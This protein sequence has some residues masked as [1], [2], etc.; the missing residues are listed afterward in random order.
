[1]KKV[2]LAAFVL[3]VVFSACL[4][5]STTSSGCTF[6]A[7]SYTAPTSEIQ[8][9]QSYL[10]SHSLTATQHCSGLFYNITNSGTGTTPNACSNITVNYTASLTNGNVFDQQNNFSF[11]LLQAISGW[12]I[13]MPLLRSGGHIILYIPPSLGYGN[14]DIKDQNGNVIIPA[15]SIIIADVDL[16]SVQ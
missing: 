2:Y 5:G 1:M 12:R 10:S 8:A 4:K 15:N 7:C 9:V 13:G 16:V 11:S 6:D 14:Q 3:P